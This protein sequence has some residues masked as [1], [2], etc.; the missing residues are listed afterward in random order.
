MSWQLLFI[1]FFLNIGSP[2]CSFLHT[3]LLHNGEKSPTLTK[4]KYLDYLKKLSS[5]DPHDFRVYSDPRST[6]SEGD[7]KTEK[8]L[9]FFAIL[10]K[11]KSYP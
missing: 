2:L 8:C 3:S 5:Y 11:R 4:L 1:I 6:Q 7:L 10:Q 9:Y